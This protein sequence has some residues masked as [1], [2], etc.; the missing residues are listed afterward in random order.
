MTV[1]IRGHRQLKALFIFVENLWLFILGRDTRNLDAWD[2]ENAIYSGRQ[3]MM[4]RLRC[5]QRELEIFFGFA[6]PYAIYTTPLFN[7]QYSKLFG[8]GALI[9]FLYKQD[10]RNQEILSKG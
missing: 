1:Y 2:M 9:E 5:A 4:D 8:E 10:E 7:Q 6:K 3:F